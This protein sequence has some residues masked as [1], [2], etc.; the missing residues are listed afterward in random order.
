MILGN[1]DRTFEFGKEFGS[2]QPEQ[3]EYSQFES[4]SSSA[5]SQDISEGMVNEE[6]QEPE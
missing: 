5:Q 6:K 1:E 2:E 3:S 4:V